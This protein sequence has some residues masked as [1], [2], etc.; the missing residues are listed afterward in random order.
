MQRRPVLVIDDDPQV[1][2]LIQDLLAGTD[3]EV[4]A[5]PDGPSGIELARTAQPAVILLDIILPGLDGLSTCQRLKQDP[6]LRNIPVVGITASDD[7][8][9]PGKAFRTGFAFFL[10]KPFRSSSLVRVVEL[11]L[12]S[13][14][15]ETPMQRRRRHP[16]LPVTLRARCLVRNDMDT[17]HEL[18]GQTGNVSLGG[19]LLLVPEKLACGTMLQLVLKLPERPVAARG[20]VMWQGSHSAEGDQFA[21]GIQLLGFGE[22]DGFFHYRRFLGDLPATNPA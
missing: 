1:S 17:A 13:S 15:P 19:L 14:Q 12:A 2:E 9:Y 18:E 22:D 6:L 20:K 3:L 10:P 16:R 8:R 7:L 21:H 11:A 5:A 4:V